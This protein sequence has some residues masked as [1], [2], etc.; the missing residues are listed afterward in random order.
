MTQAPGVWL[1]LA[2]AGQAL[3]D[4]LYP[5]RCAGCGRLGESFCPACQAR[6]EPLPEPACPRCGHPQLSRDLC[7][8]C[9]AVPSALDGIRSAAVFAH[10]L[11]DAIHAFKYNNNRDLAQPL[12]ACMAAYWQVAGL[13]ADRIVPVPLH[14]RRV[15]ERGYN[16]SALL[17]RVLGR[18][19]GLPVDERVLVRQRATA[20]QVGLGRAERQQNVAGAFGCR[21]DLAGQRLILIDDVCTTGSTLEACA[22]ALRMAGAT[23][24]W[25]FTLARARWEPGRSDAPDALA[26]DPGS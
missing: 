8:A 18:S 10:P 21:A 11:R 20:H 12:G 19:V 2:A 25:G 5:P 22:E 7:A 24:V 14:P 16:Q 17:A 1:R 6:I 4:L 3:L 23:S 9:W 15:T 26:P 13:T